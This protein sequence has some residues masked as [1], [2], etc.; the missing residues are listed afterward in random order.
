MADVRKLKD[1][2]TEA[3]QKGKFVKAAEAYAEYCQAD[4]K[5]L[6]AR[7][8]MGDAWS[9]GGKKEKAIESYAWAAEGFAK[10][11]FLPRAIAASKLILELDPSHQG[12]QKMLADLYARKS[13]APAASGGPTRPGSMKIETRVEVQTTASGF[14]HRKDAIALDAKPSAFA[15]TPE[16]AKDEPPS[17]MNRRD[18]IELPEYE[19][20]GLETGVTSGSASVPMAL[21]GPSPLRREDAI[22]IEEEA[23]GPAGPAVLD[24]RS[25]AL[26]VPDAPPADGFEL[27]VDVAEPAAPSFELKVEVAVPEPFAPQPVAPSFELKDVPEPVA[28]QPVA[29]SFKLKDE[30][31]V[32]QPVAPRPVAPGFE[33]N[34]DEAPPAQ[35]APQAKVWDL[36][37]D[38]PLGQIEVVESIVSEEIQL[39]D[40]AEA[41]LPSVK[42]QLEVLDD[43]ELEV[44]PE[45]EPEA[46]PAPAGERSGSF[47]APPGL[48]PRRAPAQVLTELEGPVEAE[49]PAPSAPRIWMPDN[50]A[51]PP[52]SAPVAPAPVAFVPA[53]ATPGGSSS[54]SL[55]DLERGL[56][57]FSSFDA[58]DFKPT[59][60]VAVEPE[61][62]LAAAP[63]PPGR[64]TF[65]ELEL[66]GDSLLHA[67]E[68]AAAVGVE[69]R[70]EQLAEPIEEAMEMPEDQKLE[71]GELPKIPL[72][73]DLPPDAFIALFER[74]P[75]KRVE[76]TEIVIAQGSLGDSFYVICAGSVRVFRT[77]GEHRRE[78]ATLEEGAFFGEMALL[79]GAART[80][81]VEAATEDTQLLEISAPILTE[82]SHRYPQVASALKKFCRQRLLSNLMNSAN[83]FQS[84]S[85]NDRRELVQRFRARDVS[86]GE[87]LIKEGHRSDGMY[88]ILS[89]EVEVRVGATAVA[90]LKE[91]DVFG[92]MSLLTKANA[93]ATVAASKHTSL[94]RLP[95]DDFNQI[96]MS[97]PQ[98]LVL[99]SE[100]TDARAKQNAAL[101]SHQ[102]TERNA[103]PM[104]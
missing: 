53:A 47:T 50:F 63:A 26:E 67:V 97:H 13:T 98:V 89:G 88:V 96:I 2:A 10:S 37:A 64:R 102:P 8:R 56:Q 28:P 25:I 38:E 76:P 34:D 70:G 103:A 84:F 86:K 51:L 92:E 83:L 23:S 94:L 46:S 95:R 45:R 100:L 58:D 4:P 16:G 35:P 61:P 36:S 93:T 72:F 59:R 66:D 62:M 99:V 14:G 19:V 82:L 33:L 104:V 11:G 90:T 12:V 48:K 29:P 30:G 91:G 78:I 31:A 54:Q 41:E 57:I 73:S 79:S 7:L 87:M 60:P 42:P 44:I 43:L 49:A 75:L 69:Q 22:E 3:F 15:K 85:R 71:P 40:L 5:D 81:S 65:T 1:R 39:V 27:N 52:P 101:A 77:D 21:K 9:K 6:Q 32:P 18:A 55:T 17:P 24:D 68:A 80:A 74:C 20:P